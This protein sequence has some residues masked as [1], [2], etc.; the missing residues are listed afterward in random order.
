MNNVFQIPL[1]ENYKLLPNTIEDYHLEN[2]MKC[3]KQEQ[4]VEDFIIK[5]FQYIHFLS[6]LDTDIFLTESGKKYV[7]KLNK[8]SSTSQPVPSSIQAP[9]L[10]YVQGGGSDINVLLGGTF[11]L[12]AFLYYGSDM[13]GTII[14][15]SIT[16]IPQIIII[17]YDRRRIIIG[18]VILQE[19]RLFKCV[20]K[21]SKNNRFKRN[22][23]TESKVYRKFENIKQINNIQLPVTDFY[24]SGENRTDNLFGYLLIEN[25]KINGTNIHPFH[26]RGDG[27]HRF[28]NDTLYYYFS[29]EY[30]TDYSGLNHWIKNNKRK[31]NFNVKYREAIQNIIDTLGNLNDNYG[32]YHGDF[33]RDNVFI[34]NDLNQPIMV[35]H[36]DFDFSGFLDTPPINENLIEDFKFN[37]RG[38]RINLKNDQH[39][40]DFLFVFDVYRLWCSLLLS[41]NTY[42][43]TDINNIICNNNNIQFRLVTIAN[44][45]K[46]NG[47]GQYPWFNQQHIP[48][49]RLLYLISEIGSQIG[50]RAR[51]VDWNNTL[52]HPNVFIELFTYI[53]NNQYIPAPVPGRGRGIVI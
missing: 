19:D 45:F 33:K 14:K 48:N 30:N 29:M 2:F 18:C 20:L 15:W 9:P 4:S 7:Y 50:V 5:H 36:I 22:Y 3:I 32:F 35:K 10:I 13:F 41:D 38:L 52:M 40:K 27:I 23:R 1:S 53:R 46:T 42:Y 28:S 47:N 26:V 16:P 44:F 6:K 12:S 37:M 11:I 34:S 24:G 43:N 8:K 39:T 31:Y 51:D 49:Q 21:V 17:N 25:V